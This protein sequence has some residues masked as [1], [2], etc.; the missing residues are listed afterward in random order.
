MLENVPKPKLQGVSNMYFRDLSKTFE[1]RIKLFQSLNINSDFC[2]R[3][4]FRD[5]RLVFSS[6]HLE[7]IYYKIPYYIRE[8][9]LTSYT[10]FRAGIIKT[11]VINLTKF[12]TKALKCIANRKSYTVIKSLSY[13]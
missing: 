12:W 11:S 13:S 8:F 5:P 7:I 2:L 9:E 6:P 4:Y 3:I 10:K 1:R